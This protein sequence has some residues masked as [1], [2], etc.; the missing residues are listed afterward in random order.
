MITDAKFIDT[1]HTKIECLIDGQPSWLD[2]DV[3]GY[4]GRLLAGWLEAGGVIAP[5][6]APAPAPK[7]WTPLE[8]MEL[9]SEEERIAIRALARQN[10][11]IEDWL[12]L[13]RASS[14][15]EANDDRTQQGLAA[16]VQVGVLTQERV[17]A[18]LN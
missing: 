8:F 7:S 11:Q 17:T 9:F 16:M 3:D 6:E 5:Y 13:L 4:I 10:P 12:D 15:V 18:I 2:A 14:A 1:A